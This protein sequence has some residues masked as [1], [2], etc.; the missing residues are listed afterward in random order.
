MPS[1]FSIL[2]TLYAPAALS[3]ISLLMLFR[4][5]KRHQTTVTVQPFGI[6]GISFSVSS[7]VL[8]RAAACISAVGFLAAYF[9]IDFSGLVPTHLQMEVF[10][11]GQGISKVLKQYFRPTD[12]DELGISKDYSSYRQLYFDKLDNEART[13]LGNDKFFSVNN[14]EVHSIGE[15]SFVVVKIEGLQRYF[16]QESK[17]E[18]THSLEVPHRPTLQFYTLF[19]KLP[20]ADDYISPS[21]TDLV[22]LRRI[23]FRPK[24]KQLLAENRT[25]KTVTFNVVVVG[26]TS[27][28]LFPWPSFSPTVYCAEFPKVG[29]VPIAYAIYK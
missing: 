28:T 9:I 5:K 8:T 22:I 16:I 17:G 6:F 4:L 3:I 2:I 20:T 24:F 14:G 19:Q 18:L 12:L 1:F 7:L 25:S 27:G 26:I 10:F 11:D 15:T 13:V 21:F 29:L 23:L